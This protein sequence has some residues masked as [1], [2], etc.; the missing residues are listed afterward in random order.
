MNH[1]IVETIFT[2]SIRPTK[3]IFFIL[4]DLICL[5]PYSIYLKRKRYKL[6]Q[7]LS[8]LRIKKIKNLVILTDNFEKTIQLWHI[9]LD[10]NFV[11]SYDMLSIILKNNI[12]KCGK[13]S[14]HKPELLFENFNCKIS[15]VL[16]TMFKRFF[17]DLPDFKG[18]QIL[19]FHK[20]KSFLF[21]RF[22]R[23]IFS[24]TG[25]DVKLQELG[26]RVT[27]K[28]KNFFKLTYLLDNF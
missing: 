7:I 8:Y 18:R 12:E 16:G 24:K 10:N 22:Y 13:V 1:K 23:Y 20:R 14:T 21:I 26:P 28:F 17:K 11:A 2:T 4:S 6:R 5:F 27:L 19:S 9:D 3:K 25:K 15:W